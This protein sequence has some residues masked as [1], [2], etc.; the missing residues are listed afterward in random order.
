[1]TFELIVR[2]HLCPQLTIHIILDDA[3]RNAVIFLDE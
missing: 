3:I 1:M 2:N